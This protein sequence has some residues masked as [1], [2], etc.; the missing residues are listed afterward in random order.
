MQWKDL[1]IDG[2]GRIL[3]MVEHTLAELPQTSLDVMPK[4]D[5]NSIGWLAWHIARVED[6]SIARLMGA[7]QLWI[8]D[9][10][11]EKFARPAEPRDVGFGH[12]SEDVAAFES[13]EKR[14]FIDYL[15][16][17]TERTKEYIESLPE[18]ELSR[19][20]AEPQYTP[21][22]TVGVR[23]VSVMADCLEHAGQMAYARGLQEGKGWQ[24]Y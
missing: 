12:K 17:V 15:K 11:H 1:I 14:I 24:K 8:T 20:L 13:P 23:L 5:V 3:E 21:L 19:E 9:K 7:K 2:Y 10:W 16:A 6:G 4:A 22:P 18:A